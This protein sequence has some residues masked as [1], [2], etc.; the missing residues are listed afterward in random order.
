MDFEI[1]GVAY[2]SSKL[3]AMQQFHVSRRLAAG[4]SVL[5][6]RFQRLIALSEKGEDMSPDEGLEIVSMLGEALAAVPQ[7]DCDY[8]IAAC[9]RAV[10]RQD[11][12]GRGWC[13]ITARD[14]ALM[15]DDIQLAEM[16]IIVWNVLKESMAGFFGGLPSVLNRGEAP[17]RPAA[18]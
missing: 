6:G 1:K 10:R 4:M 16:L 5:R 17:P 14:G 9:L 3:T 7:D 8:V 15:Y 11:G 13:A 18:G 2:R 12:G